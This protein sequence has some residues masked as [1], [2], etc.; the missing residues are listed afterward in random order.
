MIYYLQ[1]RN[2]DLRFDIS[3]HADDGNR[4]LQSTPSNIFRLRG[5]KCFL[6][7]GLWFGGYCQDNRIT[8]SLFHRTVEFIRFPSCIGIDIGNTYGGHH[9]GLSRVPDALAGGEGV[10]N[11]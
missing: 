9:D 3:E 6:Y 5:V 4:T 1:I 10:Q 2:S 11:W 7:H 8:L